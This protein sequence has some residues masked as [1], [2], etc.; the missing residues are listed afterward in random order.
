M[1][2]GQ[3]EVRRWGGEAAAV[4]LAAVASETAF[5]ESWSHGVMMVNNGRESK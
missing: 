3:G 5:I 4:A 1:V 2:L